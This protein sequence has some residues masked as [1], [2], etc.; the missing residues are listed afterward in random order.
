LDALIFD[1]D[2]VVIDSEPFHLAAFQHVL[3]SRG[4]NLTRQEYYA[5]YIG[6]DDHDA[7]LEAF[8]DSGVKVSP[9]QIAEMIAKKTAMIKKVFAE[10]IQPFPGAVGLI[11][12]AASAGVA[13][14]VC[15]GALRAEIELAAR[16]I[17]L[18]EDFRVI[19]SAQ[20]VSRGKPDPE[21][22]DLARRRLSAATGRRIAAARCVAI[23]DA[24]AGIEAATGAGMKV[25]AVTNSYAAEKLTAA[26][27]VVGSL[28]EVTVGL[29]EQ[30]LSD[31]PI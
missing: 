5:K 31:S 11:K 17:G 28:E 13:V 16:K 6:Y 22:Y 4:H 25:L 20:D 26:D 10:S 27:R 8:A 14:A 7:F 21:G 24:P 29:L 23:E 3:A 1:F 2:G 18:L 30:L 15:S 9:S 12:S 19:V